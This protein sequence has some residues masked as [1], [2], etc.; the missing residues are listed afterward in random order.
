MKKRVFII[1]DEP[2]MADIAEMLLE[3]DGFVVGKAVHPDDGLKKI[4]ANP[5][6]VILL[7]VGLPG[8][9]GFEVC[10]EIKADAKLA[11]IPVLM[12]SVRSDETNVVVGLQMG[13]DDYIS[14]PFRQ[15]ELLARVKTALRRQSKSDLPESLEVRP[16]KVDFKRH[17]VSMGKKQLD[18][19]PTEFNLLAMFLQSEGRVLTRAVI[20]ERVWGADLSS[21]SRNVDTSVDRL[22]KKLGAFGKCLKSLR[23]V[24]YQLDLEAKK[25]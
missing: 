14:K 8:K 21:S 25:D 23:G 1:D 3:A 7:D 10:R 5:P 4:R 22:R 11:H 15:Q 16:F 6:D 9:D 13:A 19:T 18:L 24:G 2:A 20:F 12:I 17:S